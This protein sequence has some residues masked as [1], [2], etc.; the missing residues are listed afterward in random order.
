MEVIMESPKWL[1]KAVFYEVY[2]Q[3]FCDSNGD[4]IGD[5]NGLRKKLDYIASMGFNA[6]WL[7]PIYESLFFDAGYDVSDYKKVAKRYGGNKAL[8]ALIKDCREKGIRLILDL[9]P[10]HTA[11]NHKWFKES[12]KAKENAY[13]DRFIWNKDIWNVDPKFSWIRGFYERNGAAMV[14]F[15]SIQPKL[16]FGFQNIEHP[17]YEEPVEGKGPQGTIKAIEDIIR[18]YLA[19][20]IDGFRVDM[21]GWLVAR[22]PNGEGTQKVW[23]QIFGDIKKEYPESAFVS[24]WAE[25]NKSLPS[26]FDMDFLLQDLHYNSFGLLCRGDHP[27]FQKDGDNQTAVKYFEILNPLI[28]NAQK[29]GRYLAMISGNHDTI[30]LSEWLDEKEAALCYIFMAT[31]PCVPFYYYGDEILMRYLKGI[32]SIEGGYQRTGSRSPMQWN[33]NKPNAGFSSNKKT[34]IRLDPKRKG[35][36]VAEEERR[37]GSL[38]LSL[39][40]ALKLK[41]E[42]PALDNDAS[43]ALLNDG[44]DGLIVYERKKGGETIRVY[45]N[46][47]A[48]DVSTS[49]KE[50]DIVYKVGEASYRNGEIALAGQSAAIVK[51]A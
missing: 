18:F 29:Q 49:C 50:G 1:E 39:K 20:G 38:L 32:P 27:F 45:I 47:R 9:V 40:G 25:P 10:G 15:F 5:L 13:S 48:N 3:S 51:I 33:N 41:Q 2:P 8:T 16:N 28:E 43:Y 14:N 17:E 11:I 36:S 19:Q 46:A 26:G 34:Y 4:G 24:E 21:A 44:K 12:C 7:N 23:R 31:M 35:I 42:H 30:R 37:P 6:I 22:D